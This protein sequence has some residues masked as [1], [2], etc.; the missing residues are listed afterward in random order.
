MTGAPITVSFSDGAVV[1]VPANAFSS[2]NGTGPVGDTQAPTA[3]SGLSSPSKSSSS[4][5]L[6]WSASTDNVGVAGYRIYRGDAAVATSS[7]T[8][9]TNYGLSAGTSYTYSVRA[10]DA[11]GNESASSNSVTVTTDGG[12]G[13]GYGHS[14]AGSSVQFYV[15]NA[16]WADVH[17]TING[18]AQQNLRM[19]QSGG[20]NSYQL[21][22]LPA[23]ATVSYRFTIGLAA[24]GATETVWTTFTVGGGAYG[25]TIS[26]SN[27]Q[28]YVNNAP[29]ADVHYTI[30]GGAQQ[31]LRMTVSGSNNTYTLPN[32]PGGATVRYRFTIGVAAGGASE[33]AWVTFAK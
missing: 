30:D 27:V 33:T 32:V 8:S 29:W 22:N 10:F 12:G 16:P 7:S 14:I 19:T 3:P 17:Y 23:G 20:N 13:S 4:V 9:F 1:T 28:F 31:N 26:G 11:A 18:G 24:G 6:S 15:N 2:G 25:H 21:T 5:T